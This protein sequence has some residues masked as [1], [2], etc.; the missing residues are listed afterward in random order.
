MENTFFEIFKTRTSHIFFFFFKGLVFE[1]PIIDQDSPIWSS[2]WVNVSVYFY[3]DELSSP[4]VS[5]ILFDTSELS[6]VSPSASFFSSLFHHFLSS[7]DD[8][9]NEHIFLIFFFLL[10]IL[11]LFRKYLFHIQHFVSG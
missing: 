4:A 3:S 5:G 10:L 8:L 9:G 7:F 2:G 11:G 6:K 1:G